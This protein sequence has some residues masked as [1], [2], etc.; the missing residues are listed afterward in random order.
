VDKSWKRFER[1]V[2]A[3]SGGRRV[4][5]ADQ[6]THLDVAHPVF[7]IECKYRAS[8]PKYLKDY[9]AQAKEGCKEGQIPVVAMGEKYSSTVYALLN[10]DDLIK[11]SGGNNVQE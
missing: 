10:F 3:K 6:E 9:F 5:V 4:P 2:A 1:R 8:L 7:G 11:L